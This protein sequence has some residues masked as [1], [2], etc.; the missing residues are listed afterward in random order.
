MKE[1]LKRNTGT[2][3]MINY[4]MT[5]FGNRKKMPKYINKPKFIIVVRHVILLHK[6]VTVQPSKCADLP[7]LVLKTSNTYVTVQNH[8]WLHTSFLL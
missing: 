1:T 3:A 8:E 4:F 7:E 6:W 5:M 2:K